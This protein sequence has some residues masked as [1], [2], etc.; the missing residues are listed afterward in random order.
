M[1]EPRLIEVA[2][3]DDGQRLDRWLKKCVPDM[4]YMLAQKLIRK[5]AIKIDG[6]RGKADTRL[7]KGQEIRI[8]AIEERGEAPP[9]PKPYQFLD[10]DGAFIKSMVIYDD[11]DLVALNKPHGLATQG[12]GDE[13]RHIDGLAEL[14]T[15]KEGL[16]PR[17]VHRLDKETSGVLLMARSPEAVRALGAAFKGRAIKKIY[18]A[19][20]V[21]VPDP[22]DGTIRAPIGKVH[23][24]IKDKMMID[25]R[26]GKG[27]ITDFI[28]L[29]HMGKEAAFVAF[30]LETGR[31]H[32]IRVHAAEILQCPVL[33]DR[34]YGG[35]A[36][37]ELET[38]DIPPRLHLHASHMAL[39][40]PLD[41]NKI[42]EITAPLPDD[43]RQSWT[44]MGFDPTYNGDPFEDKKG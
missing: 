12:G 29:D 3:E 34:K 10:G 14:L 19:I 5:G 32:Q 44:M 7:S 37:E 41:E 38:L 18:W 30:S 24:P 27:A 31:T 8:P 4:P 13:K 6:K 20:T 39:Q 25:E 26:D 1:S 33:A 22:R 2:A 23:G 35:A 42:L 9:T 28:V 17:L 11:G 15:N 40:H 43:L 21:G 36:S 16:R